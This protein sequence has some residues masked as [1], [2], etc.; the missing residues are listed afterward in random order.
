LYLHDK[1]PA[2]I[3]FVLVNNLIKQV[4]NCKIYQP[5]NTIFSG[6]FIPDEI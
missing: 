4:L 1:Q 6:T 2:D 3:G 5:K